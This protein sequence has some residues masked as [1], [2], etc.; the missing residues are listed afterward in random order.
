MIKLT[1]EEREILLQQFQALG[2]EALTYNH[3]DLAAY[4]DE[5]NPEVWKAFLMDPEIIQWKKTEL[6]IVANSEINKMIKG[7]S[8]SRSTG[9][10]QIMTAIAKSIESTTI[11]EGP[12]FIYTYVPLN[13]QEEQA[14]N[15]ERTPND[16]F[17]EDLF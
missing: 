4:T 13:A 8:K 1:P 14:P 5:H 17:R 9:Q 6:E 3:Y 10:A 15:T 11:K 2:D 7:A 16:I 12:I